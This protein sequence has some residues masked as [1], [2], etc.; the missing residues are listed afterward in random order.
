MS[1][2][3][4][5][6]KTMTSLNTENTTMNDN[7]VSDDATNS[8][9]KN[10]S[11]DNNS[12]DTANTTS[13]A[14][15]DDTNSITSAT[16]ADKNTASNAST[17]DTDSIT[18]ATYTGIVSTAST[19]NVHSNDD[20]TDNAD[21]TSTNTD[22]NA[23]TV[24][25]NNVDSKDD[26]SNYE[27]RD[28]H[29]YKNGVNIGL[30]DVN[31]TDRK[32][33][34]IATAGSK[35]NADGGKVNGDKATFRE[36]LKANRV[37]LIVFTVIM[38]LALVAIPLW[39]FKIRYVIDA[40]KT[41]VK[42]SITRYDH[43]WEKTALP[44]KM[45]DYKV[46]TDQY[47]QK[48]ANG[49]NMYCIG[50]KPGDKDGHKAPT[51]SHTMKAVL[52]FGDTKSRNFIMQN[53]SPISMGIKSGY[54]NMEFC[55]V[56]TDNEYSVL[57]VEALAESDY[58]DPS[59]TWDVINDLMFTP[60]SDLKNRDERIAAIMNVLANKIGVS[61]EKGKTPINKD[62]IEQGSFYLFGYMMSETQRA[63]YIPAL[64]VDN[65]VKNNDLSIYNPDD[66]WKYIKALPNMS[67]VLYDDIC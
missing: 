55:F 16:D 23:S 47:V 17:D 2:P 14:S 56:Q 45:K 33:D 35:D 51:A 1:N 61:N 9:S 66:M 57:A 41:E 32:S 60:T 64:F 62:S 10:T 25:V 42:Y 36:V 52:A 46:N 3:D 5:T 38:V 29:L 43:S 6:D 65:T 34:S 20:T 54:I 50:F 31:S 53:M 24:N 48:D 30:V 13:N 59:H 28:G 12:A 21:T 8:V 4:E 18:S 27:V 49:D 11:I 19:D 40:P 44:D 67:H 37:F 7:A 26:A 15:T 58:I 39:F 63:D 22:N